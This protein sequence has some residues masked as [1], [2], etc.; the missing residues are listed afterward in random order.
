M[1][2][3]LR[4]AAARAPHVR[5]C[6]PTL[7]IMGESPFQTWFKGHLPMI[8]ADCRI[9]RVRSVLV[10]SNGRWI[11]LIGAVNVRDLGGLPTHD[12]ET[13]R[14]GRVLRADNLQDLAEADTS[15]LVDT[16]GLT[17][18]VDLRSAAEIALEGPGPLNRMPGVSIHHF[19]MLAEPEGQ[20][21]I[22]G[23][24]VLPWADQLEE[25]RP[26]LPPGEFYLVTLK[27]RPDAVL[28]AL[29]IM[30]FSSG[31]VLAHCAAGKDRTGVL[32][33]LALTAVG[34]SREAIIEDYALTNTRIE[35]I[36]DRL[37][38][39]PTYAEDL[40]SRPMS[41]HFALP[42]SMRHFLELADEQVGGLMEWLG[43][44]GWTSADTEALRARLLA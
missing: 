3:L 17:D 29:R 24:A 36:V 33:A 19:P 27:Q 22:D 15:H 40:N 6:S 35:R 37:K 10:S 31:S 34:V 14:F 30:A 21:G 44:H 43:S 41:S 18:V 9:R 1:P 38:A 32:V 8:N 11:D 42:E 7:L 16:L 13:T 28:G 5:G 12:G 2:S 4:S 23:E 39:T 20:T 25:D 26:W